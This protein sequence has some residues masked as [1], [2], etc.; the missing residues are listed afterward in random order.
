MLTT[1]WEKNANLLDNQAGISVGII[2]RPLGK[3]SLGGAVVGKDED[4]YSRNIEG[5]ID[6][7]FEIREKYKNGD[8]LT[9][10]VAFALLLG[11]YFLRSTFK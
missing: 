2:G 8:M 11:L 1:G 6:G 4:F 10:L 7:V 5:R 9:H 3:R